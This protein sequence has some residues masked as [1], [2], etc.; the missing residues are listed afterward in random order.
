MIPKKLDGT[1]GAASQLAPSHRLVAEVMEDDGETR[2]AVSWSSS[3]SHL[4]GVGQ[5]APQESCTQSEK[6]NSD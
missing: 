5:A 1:D 3:K 2:L 6:G 4:R